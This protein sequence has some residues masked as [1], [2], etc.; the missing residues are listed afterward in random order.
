MHLGPKREIN[1]LVFVPDHSPSIT[2]LF[3]TSD[4]IAMG[5]NT[6]F[7]LKAQMGS[8]RDPSG[9]HWDRAILWLPTLLS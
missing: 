7:C 3:A 1:S 9:C 2:V 8:I 4:Y 5:R 6:I